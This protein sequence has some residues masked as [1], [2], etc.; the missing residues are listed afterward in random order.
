V[1]ILATERLA[2]RRSRARRS[3]LIALVSTVVFA[4]VVLQAV[5]LLVQV[6]LQAVQL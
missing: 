2:F 4:V 1:T 5:L 3:T 6:V